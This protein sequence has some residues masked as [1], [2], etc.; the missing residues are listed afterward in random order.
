MG[1]AYF[2]CL[3]LGIVSPDSYPV[4]RR[5]P[6]YKFVVVGG[7]FFSVDTDERTLREGN[8]IDHFTKNQPRI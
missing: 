7:S 4:Q 1:D 3:T 2:A 6:A 8:A 5:T